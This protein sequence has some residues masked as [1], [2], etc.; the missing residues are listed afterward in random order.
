MIKNRGSF[1]KETIANLGF[2]SYLEIGLSTNPNA[3]YRLINLTNKSSVDTDK[4][5]NP[6]FC[7]SS[8]DF[9]KK[10]ENEETKF[11][12]NYKWDC[13]FIDGWHMADQVYTDL[14]NSFN[15]LSD[16]GIIFMHDCLPWNYQITIEQAVGNIGATCQDAWKTVEYC[17]KNESGMHICTLEEN[18]GGLAVVI[19]NKQNK[20]KML[21]IN[22]N[23]FFQ[24]SNYAIDR[25][26][27][28]NCIDENILLEWISNP[29][30][31][32]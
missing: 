18:E 27:N 10:L 8:D 6:D 20:R 1:I 12:K 28:M 4:R 25:N 32:F 13:I 19:K 3:P 9:F 21:D 11:D 22:H 2:Q 24:Y 15:H 16:N 23:R 26:K 30:Y 5:T 7:M 17:L 29:T 14:L 31:N